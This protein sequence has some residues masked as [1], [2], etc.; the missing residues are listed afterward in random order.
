MAH[1]L[2]DGQA[3]L[4]WVEFCLCDRFKWTLA[5]VRA[6][7]AADGLQLLTLMAAEAKAQKAKAR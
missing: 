1:L 2:T 4:E 3:P 5:H 6:L 7:P